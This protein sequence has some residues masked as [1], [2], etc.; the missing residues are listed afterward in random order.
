MGDRLRV[1]RTLPGRG[2]WICVADPACLQRATAPERLR[3]AFR[4]SIPSGASESLLV[5]VQT[6]R[7]GLGSSAATG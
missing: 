7:C 2:A 3:R 5:D 4:R 1:G 6:G